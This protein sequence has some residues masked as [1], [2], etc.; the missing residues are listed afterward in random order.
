MF[1]ATISTKG[2]VILDT[3]IRFIDWSRNN[4]LDTMF[5]FRGTCQYR[6]RV[7]SLNAITLA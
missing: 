3:M 6:A 2:N 7:Y 5:V 1:I 4:N